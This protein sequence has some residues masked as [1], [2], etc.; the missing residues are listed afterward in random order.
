MRRKAKEERDG[1][2]SNT[3]KRRVKRFV[4]RILSWKIFQLAKANKKQARTFFHTYSIGTPNQWQYPA[5]VSSS[6]LYRVQSEQRDFMSNTQRGI[7][8]LFTVGRMHERA[9]YE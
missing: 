9:H 8:L 4:D 5:S 3:G 7:K 2:R 6:I 1:Y